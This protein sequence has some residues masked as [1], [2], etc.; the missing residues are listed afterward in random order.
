[1]EETSKVKLKFNFYPEWV[2]E[3]KQLHS[4]E[5]LKRDVKCHRSC[6][7][8]RKCFPIISNIFIYRVTSEESLGAATNRIEVFDSNSVTKARK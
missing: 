5:Y 4:I 2:E 7:F 8:Q 1:M 6:A 3:A